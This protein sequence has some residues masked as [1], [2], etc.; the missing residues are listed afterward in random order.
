M[1]I[2]KFFGSKV[3]RACH[4][5]TI[6]LR[7]VVVTGLGTFPPF[8]LINSP[9]IGLVS[10]LGSNVQSSWESLIKGESGIKNIKDIEAYKEDPNYP[11]CVVATIH[12]S[13]DKKKWEVPVIN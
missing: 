1:H 10:P 13:F 2:S 12:E 4:F 5:S 7:R 6:T 9:S 8:L 3:Q 11:A